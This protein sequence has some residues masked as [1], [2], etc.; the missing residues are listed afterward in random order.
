MTPLLLA[1]GI[2]LAQWLAIVAISFV[3]RTRALVPSTLL[4]A[5]VYGYAFGAPRGI[6]TAQASALPATTP[7]SAGSCAMIDSGMAAS[8][9]RAKMG[10]PHEVRDDAKTRGPGAA[11]WIYRDSRCAVH[12]LDEKVELVD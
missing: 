1:L 7:A 8:E 3:K 2:A 12:I 4:L 5:I 6:A 10:E 9:V 11:T